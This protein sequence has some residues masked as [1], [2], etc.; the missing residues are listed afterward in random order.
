MAPVPSLILLGAGGHAKVL[1]ALAAAAGMTVDGVCDPGLADRGEAS[2]H[3]IAV[4][5]GD[6][7]LARCDPAE[8]RLINGLG[9]VAGG[10]RRAALF[11]ECVARGFLFPPLV[12]PAAWVAP[13]ARLG[14]GVQVMAGAVVQPDV[15]IGANSIVNTRASIDHDCAL[16]QDVHIAPGAVLCGSV[17]VA[18]GAFV[19]SGATI[20]QGLSVGRGAIVGAGAV[21]VRDLAAGSFLLAA[22]GPVRPA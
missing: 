8:V 6:A 21:M 3:G 9:Q 16:G 14:Q 20:I 4:L 18:D 13:T 22:L 7:A 12:H 17:R 19:G 1:L 10:T 11:A 15:V 5:G 2:W